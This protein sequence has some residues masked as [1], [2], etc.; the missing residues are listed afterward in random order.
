MP[1]VI[2]DNLSGWVDDHVDA[3]VAEFAPEDDAAVIMAD[4]EGTDDD[5]KDDTSGRV[6]TM[7]EGDE[8]GAG[9]SASS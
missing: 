4:E 9:G 7:D 3:L 6:G 1:R 8:D 2:R 5:D